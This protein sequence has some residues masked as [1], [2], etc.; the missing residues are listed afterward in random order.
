MVIT[1]SVIYS[2]DCEADQE[3]RLTAA[4]Q[5]CE[6]GPRSVSLSS[7]KDPN[8]KVQV[9]CLMNLSHVP[10]IVKLKNHKSNC[11][12]LGMVSMN[13]SVMEKRKMKWDPESAFCF[14]S[15]CFKVTR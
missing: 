12:K 15:F 5:H 9:W 1:V 4:A 3:L 10:T 11:L 8:S 14:V 7:R 13:N 6:R 2:G